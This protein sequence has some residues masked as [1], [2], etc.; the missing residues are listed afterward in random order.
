MKTLTASGFS[1]LNSHDSFRSI[2]RRYS[3]FALLALVCVALLSRAEAVNPSPDGGYPGGNTAEGQ[4]ALLS[5]TTG[6]YNAAFG[7]LSLQ[8]LTN[9]SFCTGVGA[10]TL[11]L[12][13]AEENSATGAGALLSNTVGFENTAN[14]AFALFSNTG[15]SRNNAFGNSALLSHAT[16]SFN[17]AVGSF[18]LYSDTGGESNN[19]FGDSALISNTTG[20]VNTAM[21]DGALLSNTT[22]SGNV[23]VG[24][25]A[26]ASSTVA[27]IDTSDGASVAVGYR[28]L[29]NAS[30]GG[31][32][33]LGQE[34]LG[35]NTTGFFNNA[36][37][38]GALPNVTS[39][40][41]NTAIGHRAG[42][43]LTT[44]NGNVY[45]GAF[46]LPTNVAES[47]TTRILNI[48][49]SVVTD[50]VVYVNPEGKLGTLA[51][52][53]RFKD[54][55]KPMDTSSE[56]LFRLKPVTF[57]YKKEIDSR[58]APQ[59]GLV[60][61]EVAEV[62]PDLVVRD[63]QGE[64]YTVRYE[65]VNAM[66]LN[67]FLKEHRKVEAQESKIKEQRCKVQEQ[68]ATI[69]QLTKDFRAT[70]VQLTTRLD[71]QAS[72]IQKMSHQL[73]GA[74]PFRGELELT[75]PQIVLN[76]R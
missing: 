49:D 21:G 33:A 9:G 53:R 38:A 39:G 18:S 69:T 19:A 41:D 67:E 17:N 75:A 26:L 10:G 1:P 45:I 23:A 44:G 4:A 11:L 47:N 14:G 3:A 54:D 2:T 56:P 8:A 35:N 58:R 52:S 76:S 40:H 30:G 24:V 5:R 66:L 64:I 34:A 31:N 57:R 29:Q 13:T 72:Q 55:I 62:S 74:I 25:Q 27:G 70:V 37:G 50:R 48:Y 12:N 7:Y 32:N 61:E 43:G 65:A 68:E 6:T 20:M 51:S 28:A 15:G 71:E 73:A 46:V 59:F 22:G 63:K 36:F 60:A 42:E 16:G